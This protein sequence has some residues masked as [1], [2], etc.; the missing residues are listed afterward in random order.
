M[1]SFRSEEIP[2]SQVTVC[3]TSTRATS[4]AASPPAIH[5]S[6]A[7]AVRKL[8]DELTG[9]GLSGMYHNDLHGQSVLSLRHLTIWCRNGSFMWANSNHAVQVSYFDL[10]DAVEQIIR[11]NED[12]EHAALAPRPR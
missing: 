10:I 5:L 3:P 2:V 11:I 8:R 1:R 7:D 12:H 4:L 6:P 9:R